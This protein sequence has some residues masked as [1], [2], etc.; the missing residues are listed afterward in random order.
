[1]PCL[2]L[3]SWSASHVNLATPVSCTCSFHEYFLMIHKGF[4]IFLSF[5]STVGWLWPTE[6][7]RSIV[8]VFPS[9]IPTLNAGNF[10][11]W[12]MRWRTALKL[13]YQVSVAASYSVPLVLP[14]TFP[15]IAHCCASWTEIVP[16]V[17]LRAT[18]VTSIQ[19]E[20]YQATALQ[21]LSIS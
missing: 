2:F 4:L 9:S 12:P 21:L 5:T 13:R 6:P 14:G 11:Q 19:I 15:S 8:I 7:H 16:S 3:P 20:V 18:F 10:P 17:L 1:M